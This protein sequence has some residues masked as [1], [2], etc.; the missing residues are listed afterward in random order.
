MKGWQSFDP[1]WRRSVAPR[2]GCYVILLGGK[3]IY[4]GQSESVQR[5][6]TRYAFRNVPGHEQMHD[7]HTATPWG[8]FHW[9]DGKI[10][11]K[12]RYAI[13]FGE[14][15]MAEA[16]LIRKLKPRLNIRGLCNGR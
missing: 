15:L 7:G 11:G 13:K 4:V 10:T 2:P 3:A 16:R 5:R 14:H 1:T 12:V 6:I 9:R 8:Y